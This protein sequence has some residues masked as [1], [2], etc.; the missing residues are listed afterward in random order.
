MSEKKKISSSPLCLISALVWGIS[1]PM[2][3]IASQNSH[4]LDAFGFNGFRMLIAFL[5]L[6]PMVLIFERRADYSRKRITDTVKYSILAGIVLFS[7]ST[8]QQFGIEL[9]GESGKAGFI[10]SLYLVFVPI[11]AFALFKQKPS[12]LVLVA[13]PFALCGLYFLSFSNG[14]GAVHIGDLLVLVCS[15]LYA[16]HIIVLDKSSK[17][18]NPFLF[19]GLQFLV[20]GILS[21]CCGFIFGTVTAQG[22]GKTV[23]P[24]VYCGVFSVGIAYTCQLLGQ[25]NGNPTVC[26]LFC[27]MEALFAVIA[28]CIIEQHLPT[29]KIIIGCVLMLIA[30]VLSQLPQDIFKRKK[31]VD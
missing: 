17:C 9:T 2:Q 25:K 1:F 31:Q 14:F 15:I 21:L 28:E 24:I 6:I 29:P 7:A 8:F 16:I 18:T 10:T 12:L 23:L 26:A 20:A 4:L 3:E 27:S 13:M 19:S 22:I 11:I 30:V 5:A